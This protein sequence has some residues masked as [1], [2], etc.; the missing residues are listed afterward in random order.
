M[1]TPQLH[2]NICIVV[3]ASHPIL[4]ASLEDYGKKYIKRETLTAINWEGE[5]RV[6]F[7]YD[8]ALCLINIYKNISIPI[9]KLSKHNLYEVIEKI[10]VLDI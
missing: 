7:P 10:R 9:T 5:K 1:L 3:L 8:Y 4:W 6:T 2:H